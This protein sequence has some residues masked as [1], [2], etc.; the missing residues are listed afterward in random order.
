MKFTEHALHENIQKG[1]RKAG[2]TDSMPVQIQTFKQ[3]LDNQKDVCVQSQTGTGKT[4]AFLISVFQLLLTNGFLQKKKALI[5]APTR[6]LAVQITKEAK[7]LGYY[8]NLRIGCFYG[9]IGFDKQEALLRKGVDVVIGTPGRL[10]DFSQQRKLDFRKI[11]ILVID[12]AD[13]LFDMGFLPDIRR[14]LKK[15]P[16]YNERRTMLFSATLDYRVK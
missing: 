13:R 15:M 10:L 14:M 6:E 3:T 16:P 5:V 7:L 1:I 2:F 9:G 12:E 4:A 11:G 8:L